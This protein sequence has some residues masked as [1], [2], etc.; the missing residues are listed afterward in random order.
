MVRVAQRGRFS[1]YVFDERGE[2]HHRPHRHVRWSD[3]DAR[4][5][6]P[7]LVLLIG[8]P[9]PKQARDL[10]QDYAAELIAAWNRLNPGREI[11]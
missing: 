9:L 7:D 8:G 10:V 3:G 2:P 5:A 4:V 1:L 11:E 6:L